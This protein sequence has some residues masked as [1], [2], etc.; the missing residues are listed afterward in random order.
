MLENSKKERI[1][2]NMK[3]FRENSNHRDKYIYVD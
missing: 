3:I 1:D 2:M